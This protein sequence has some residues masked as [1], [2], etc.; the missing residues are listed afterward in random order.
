[1]E[2][3]RLVDEYFGSF[4]FKIGDVMDEERLSLAITCMHIHKS[5]M[6]E[7]T[8]EI[9]QEIQVLYNND[10]IVKLLHSVGVQGFQLRGSRD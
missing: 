8:L 3:S 1:M 2:C 10:L 7:I 6:Q 4:L 5:V 9:M